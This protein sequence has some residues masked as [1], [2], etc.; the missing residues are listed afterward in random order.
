MM[1]QTAPAISAATIANHG[2]DRLAA[3]SRSKASNRE[4][5]GGEKAKDGLLPPLNEVV[6][7]KDNLG[8]KV[9]QVD[10]SI[11]AVQS[12]LR[13]LGDGPHLYTTFYPLSHGQTSSLFS[14]HPPHLSS[15]SGPQ[16][17]PL[18]LQRG[19]GARLPT[20]P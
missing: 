2:V 16:S 12:R 17:T 13:H 7:I 5:I 8:K 6:L 3:P 20:I 11:G 1:R 15:T 9:H 10:A 19:R 4:L 18:P 14:C